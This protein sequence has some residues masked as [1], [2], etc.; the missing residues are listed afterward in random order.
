MKLTRSA[1]TSA[2]AATS[3]AFVAATA[4]TAA[5]P[6]GPDDLHLDLMPE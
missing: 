2:A 4:A 6:K 1:L 3:L 5:P